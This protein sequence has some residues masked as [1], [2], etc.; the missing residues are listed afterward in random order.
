MF[1]AQGAGAAVRDV[2]LGGIVE[3]VAFD[4]TEFA[5]DLL[6]NG[7]V[8]QVIAQKP[9]DMGYFA[10]LSAVAHARGIHSIPKRWST[11]YEVINLN[12]VDDPR[13]ARFIYREIA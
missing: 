3:V 9:A 12:N 7:T 5:I 11:G 2:G 8:T 10:V 6:R 13:I 4:A 1:S